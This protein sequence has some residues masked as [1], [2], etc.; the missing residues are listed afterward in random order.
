M[1]VSKPTE[2]IGL[3]PMRHR[4]TKLISRIDVTALAAILCVLMMV[5]PL[6]LPR[7][8]HGA[9]LDLPRVSHATR[10][11]GAA[12]EDALRVAIMRDGKIF[13]GSYQVF[14]EQLPSKIQEQVKTGSPPKAYVRADARAR[15][16]TVL[17]V[18]WF[19]RLAGVQDV[20]FLVQESTP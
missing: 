13:L 6:C 8:G 18:L 12:R 19:I 16:G 3:T 17:E 7:R 11:V 4:D 10:M 14:P 1:T 9:G 15:Y 20:A 2:T 5:Y